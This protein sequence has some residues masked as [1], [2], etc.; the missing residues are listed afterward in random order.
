MAAWQTKIKHNKIKKTYT[1]KQRQ[2]VGLL[3]ATEK[4][5]AW[6]DGWSNRG[7][8]EGWRHIAMYLTYWLCVKS[9]PLNMAARCVALVIY[10]RVSTLTLRLGVLI[11]AVS[12][13]SFSYQR[14]SSANVIKYCFGITHRWSHVTDLNDFPVFLPFRSTSMKQNMRALTGPRHILCF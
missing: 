2:D 14:S 8:C 10:S 1:P 9:H 13:G 4:G 7:M 6:R 11:N 12:T 5:K 3:T